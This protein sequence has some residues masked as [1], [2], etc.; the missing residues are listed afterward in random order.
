MEKFVLHSKS[1][2]W[3][4]VGR[5]MISKNKPLKKIRYVAQGVDVEPKHGAESVRIPRLR[6]RLLR[7]L[8]ILRLAKPLGGFSG[9]QYLFC[10]VF[11]WFWPSDC[12]FFFLAQ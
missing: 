7:L 1:L 3:W 6:M 2:S 12:H 8:R 9:Q 4:G 10:P 11:V 5:T